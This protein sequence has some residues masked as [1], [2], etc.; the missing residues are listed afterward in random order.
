MIQSSSKLRFTL[1]PYVNFISIKAAK[2]SNI[3]HESRVML[4][5]FII[6]FVVLKKSSL[7]MCI[8]NY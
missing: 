4:L 7:V 1:K 6:S 2:A 3:E 8:F 5:I